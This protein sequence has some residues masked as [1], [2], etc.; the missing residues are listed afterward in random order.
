LQGV[1]ERETSDQKKIV[2]KSKIRKRYK[3]G[4][5]VLNHLRLVVC[6]EWYISAVAKYNTP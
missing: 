2:M 6:E 4:I 3:K 5:E 1:Q